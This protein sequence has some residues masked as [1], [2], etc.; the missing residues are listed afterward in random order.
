MR[1]RLLRRG[2]N[3]MHKNF[4]FI[5]DLALLRKIRLEVAGDK[6]ELM[7]TARQ[8]FDKKEKYGME[9]DGATSLGVPST[10]EKSYS[11][12]HERVQGLIGIVVV[13]HGG[14]ARE[15]VAA[16][17]H[18]VGECPNVVAVSVNGDRSTVQGEISAAAD[19]VDAGCGVVI[20][21]DI[22][23]GSPSNLSLGKSA[24]SNRTI[25]FGANLPMLIKLVKSSAQSVDRAVEASIQAGR[26]YM[27]SI[28]NLN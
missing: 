12:R 7:R 18:V 1:A 14:L 24:Q 16:L 23:G 2:E 5:P 8:P 17:E 9:D 10:G 25:I 11:G 28:E 3:A 20:V 27:S 22:F 6:E 26:K 19:A 15:Y 13:A 4:Q 21:T